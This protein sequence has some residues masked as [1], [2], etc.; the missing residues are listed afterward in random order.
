MT[1]S[2]IAELVEA[3]SLSTLCWVDDAGRPRARGVVALVRDERPALAFTYADAEVAREVSGSAQVALALNETRSTTAA[4]HPLLLTGR[5]HLVED[6]SGD[7]FLEDLVVQELRRYPPSRLFADSPLLMREHWWYLPRLV[8]ELDVEAAAPLP[9]RSETHDHVL[10]VA[11]G[12]GPA[13]AAA[14]IVEGSAHRLEVSVEGRGLPTGPAVLFGQE[15]SFP[16]L[17]QWTQWRYRGRWEGSALVV[18]DAPATTGL[19]PAPSLLQRWRR[20]RD[21]KRRCVEAIP[22]PER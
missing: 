7:I 19:G 16:D 15:A 21:L 14:G 11:E 3:S 4:F 20:Q 12:S 5:P 8:V 10:V 6:A 1:S 2:D 9:P 13:V 17:E 22:R 18:E